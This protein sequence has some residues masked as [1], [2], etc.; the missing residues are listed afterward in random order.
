MST[1]SEPK[2]AGHGKKPSKSLVAVVI[3]VVVVVIIAGVALVFLNHKPSTTTSKS[4]PLS[5]LPGVTEI[6]A[7]QGVNITFTTGVASS[8]SFTKAIW[9]FGDGTIRTVT[10]NNGNTSYSYSVPGTYLASVIVYNSTSQLSNNASLIEITVLPSSVANPA[11][12]FGPVEVSATSTGSTNQTIPVG[13][14]VNLSFAGLSASSPETIGTPVPSDTSYNITSFA[15]TVDGSSHIIQNST[16]TSQGILNYTFTTAGIHT[17]QFI[18][19]TSGSGGSVTGEYNVTIAVGNYSIQQTISKVS[20]NKNEIVDAQYAPG[21][22]VSFD[23]QIDNDLLSGNVLNSIYQGLI[24]TTNDSSNSFYPV[25]ATNVPTIS[26]GEITSWN[27]F[28]TGS[29]ALNYTFYIN[30]SLQ[31]SNGD[32]VTAY[33]VYASIARAL[34]FSNGATGGF[35][36]ANILIPGVSFFGPF[37]ESFYWIHHAIT[38]NNTTQS[39][40]FHLLPGIPTWLPNTSA[41]YAGQSYGMLNQ[42]YQVYNYGEGPDFLLLMTVSNFAGTYPAIDDYSWLMQHNAFPANNSAAYAAFS[43]T[44]TG[45][46]SITNQNQY[47]KWNPMGT[48]PYYL[49]FYSSAQEAILKVNPY[50][51]QTP[52]TLSSTALIPE[53]VIEY[54]TSDETA[55]QQIESG[56]AT[57]AYGAFL[58]S[59][60]PIAVNLIHEGILKSAIGTSL[61]IN[62]FSFSLDFNVTGAKSLDAQTNIPATFF[63]NLSVRKAFTYAFNQSYWIDVANTEDGIAFMEN[64]TG[65]I[66]SDIPGYSANLSQQFPFI[67]NLSLATHYWEQTNY[68]KTGQKYYFPVFNTEGSPNVDE[69]YAEYIQALETMSNGQ[70]VPEE[71]LIS[72]PELLEY[73]AEPAGVDPITIVP[74]GWV[75]ATASYFTGLYLGEYGFQFFSDGITP[76]SA[77]N[78]TSY[79]GQW[80][81]LET[82]WNYLN[83]AMATTN[84]TQS[85]IYYYDAQKIAEG[86]FLYFGDSLSLA[87]LYYSSA[88]NPNSLGLTLLNGVSDTYYYQIQYNS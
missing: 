5:I 18:T 82:M 87:I 34:L 64:N 9:N 58:V 17:V 66:P 3:V 71:V 62:A 11:A 74:T 39:V 19:T 28:G 54:L 44:T 8:M 20:V 81:Q 7:V 38:W 21:G 2:N 61:N 14:W 88:V 40:T 27:F 77:F 85:T 51:H 83:E 48:G 65:I 16:G 75:G 53:V 69:M 68:S 29:T 67:Y 26:N 13:G 4:K 52:G 70:L 41:V 43:N 31:F 72:F 1:Q 30:T 50:Y 80:S 73:I 63:A 15:W 84:S 76:P 6:E 23:P 78:S 55:I 59:E 37:N 79:P 12:I 86:L 45:Q 22:P 32:H 49:A 47:V 36:I 35:N 25:I 56:Q 57:F 24:Q 46:V 42:T 10:T 33:D 60:T